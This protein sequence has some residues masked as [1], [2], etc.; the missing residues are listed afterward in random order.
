[1]SDDDNLLDEESKDDFEMHKSFYACVRSADIGFYRGGSRIVV[2]MEDMGQFGWTL[3]EHIAR[4]ARDG[5]EMNLTVRWRTGLDHYLADFSMMTSFAEHA[6]QLISAAGNIGLDV[7]QARVH[8]DSDIDAIA[9][10]YGLARVTHIQ[11]G[12]GQ[13]VVDVTPWV[14]YLSGFE[15]DWNFA[16]CDAI[17]GAIGPHTIDCR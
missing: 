13:A 8:I 10:R 16:L 9:Q 14:S 1:M 11:N 4:H 6:V 15:K 5:D 12:L 7:A 3:C 2:D 17:G